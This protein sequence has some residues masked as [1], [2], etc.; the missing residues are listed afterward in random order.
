MERRQPI[1]VTGAGKGTGVGTGGTTPVFPDYSSPLANSN[2]QCC[3]VDVRFAIPSGPKN[4]FVLAVFGVTVSLNCQ[5]V[6]RCCAPFGQLYLDI[7]EEIP[8]S[9]Q[10]NA[11]E[12][13]RVAPPS[14]TTS[15]NSVPPSQHG[16]NSPTPIRQYHE[17]QHRANNLEMVITKAM[18]DQS[19]E[20]IGH[21]PQEDD[22]QDD[23]LYDAEHD[24]VL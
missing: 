18:N 23:V 15:S 21:Y 11:T 17:L 6:C 4:P 10:S 14:S 22:S 8:E 5:A 20:N 7:M 3:C 12:P 13:Y 1:P 19:M 2:C 9:R 24:N 16:H